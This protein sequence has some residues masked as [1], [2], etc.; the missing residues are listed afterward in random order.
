L[1]NRRNPAKKDLKLI[2]VGKIHTKSNFCIFITYFSLQAVCVCGGGG[3]LIYGTLIHSSHLYFETKGL[4]QCILLHY[5]LIHPHFFGG[6]KAP[7]TSQNDSKFQITI[8]LD[9]GQGKKQAF[10]EK[11]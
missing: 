5:V 7:S 4:T 1:K 2:L 10:I 3:A 6:Q 9:T 11:I 8:F